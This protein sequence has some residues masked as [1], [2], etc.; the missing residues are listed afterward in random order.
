MW[1]ALGW[2]HAKL[3]QLLFW[4]LL[5]LPRAGGA[6]LQVILAW[7]GEEFRRWVSLAAAGF[8]LYLVGKAVMRFSPPALKGPLALT[9]ASLLGLWAIA[10]M[11]AA[12]YTWHNSLR[13]VRQ[14][15]AFRQLAGDVQGIRRGLSARLA[16]ATEGTP[17]GGAF[18]ANRENRDR[19]EAE[20]RRV[21][22]A[23][24]EEAHRRDELAD[25]EPSP[26]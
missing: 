21:E 2:V 14:R 24:T 22:D 13:L 23:A 25:L 4:L 18:K 19:A 6:F 7:L 5:L 3:Y 12:H 1:K 20:A 15:L 16:R 17:M 26:Y 8:L 11:R 10:L 9:V